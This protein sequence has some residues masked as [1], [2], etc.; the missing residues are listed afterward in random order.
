MVKLLGL[1]QIVEAKLSEYYKNNPDGDN[2]EK[3]WEI[4]EPLAEL[5]TDIKLKSEL[6]I[7]MAAIET[8]DRINQ[9]ITYNLNKDFA[10]IIEK[11]SPTEKLII[12]SVTLTGESI[13]GKKPYEI[14]QNISKWRN[15]YAH[16]HC[17]DRPTKSMRHNHL[18]NPKNYKSIPSAIKM[19]VD[20]VAGYLTLYDY[21][22]E[23]S[24]NVHMKGRLTHNDEINFYLN[25]ISRY[26][27]ETQ[28]GEIYQTCINAK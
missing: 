20:Y 9:I 19:M 6:A 22:G 2:D 23:I 25:E 17:T 1:H 11:L 3:F 16:G 10:E 7:F 24:Q 21:L 5:E 14:V 12:L 13:K 4:Y 15:S 28:G 18:I 8:E 27:F 26:K